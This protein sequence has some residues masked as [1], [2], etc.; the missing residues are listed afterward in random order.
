M[1]GSW[2]AIGPP[3]D[4][5]LGLLLAA[6][7][8]LETVFDPWPSYD[9]WPGA[10]AVNGIVVTAM[11]L[12]LMWRRRAALP[13][14][15]A[16]FAAVCGLALGYGASQTT[17]SFFV[18]GTAVYSAGV[19]AG[20]PMLAA[21]VIA[22]GIVIRDS[23]DPSIHSFGD[24]LWDWIFVGTAFSIGLATRRRQAKVTISERR[25][26]AAELEHAEQLAAAA[27]EERRRIARELHDVVSHSLAV[28]VLQAG[29]AE[30]VMD[31]DPEAARAVLRSIR[32]SGLEAIGEM[33][34]LL[35]V[36]RAES[37][38]TREPQPSLADLPAVIGKMESA[39]LRVTLRSVGEQRPLA[40]AVELSAY[41]IAQEGLTNA[42]KH[43]GSSQVTVTLTY[44]DH[45][46]EVEVSDDGKASTRGGGARSGLAG[47]RERVAIFGG[48]L[49]AGPRPDGGWTLRASLPT[50][51]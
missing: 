30:Q 41:R 7:G 12:V 16:V 13:V 22:L 42:L 40:A 24:H 31:D 45:E 20:S 49:D 48:R 29:A 11:G 50:A 37:N 2:G 46:V 32:D 44:R 18:V 27:D 14:L 39:G 25:R 1:R 23:Q 3:G 5:A 35:D 10:R 33:G 17:V 28:V 8:L 34:T 6:F 9:H 43:A 36:I 47:M 15:F 21:A 4:I 38:A 26:H 19:Y 51:R